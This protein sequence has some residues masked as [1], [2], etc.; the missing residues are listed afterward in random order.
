MDIR[1]EYELFLEAIAGL[2]LIDKIQIKEIH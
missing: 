1:K 2:M